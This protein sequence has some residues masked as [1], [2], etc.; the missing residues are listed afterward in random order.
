MLSASIFVKPFTV[1]VFFKQ[2]TSFTLFILRHSET[3]IIV[4]NLLML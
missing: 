2:L 1:Q 4:L 3:T